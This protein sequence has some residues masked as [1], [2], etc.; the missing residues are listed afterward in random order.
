MA[1]VGLVHPAVVCLHAEALGVGH[2]GIEYAVV[3]AQPPL[4]ALQHRPARGDGQ[5]TI[6]NGEVEAEARRDAL[7]PAPGERHLQAQ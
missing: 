4:D 2:L 5:A 1:L 3:E 6:A 7:V